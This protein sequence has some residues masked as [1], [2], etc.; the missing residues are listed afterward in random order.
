MAAPRSHVSKDDFDKHQPEPEPE[1]E[2]ERWQCRA[3]PVAL[4]L[5]PEAEDRDTVVELGGRGQE[6]E[7]WEAEGWDHESA[8]DGV[9]GSIQRQSLWARP[10]TFAQLTAWTTADLVPPGP[11][12]PSIR[13]AVH[14]K[15]IGGAPFPAMLA[16][17]DPSIAK[18]TG[19][20]QG[21]PQSESRIRSVH[22]SG[23]Y[24]RY[25]CVSFELYTT[26]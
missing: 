22:E 20:V 19:F 15:D 9:C 10:V 5:H 1:P 23:R 17:L 26:G 21:S 13:A 12:M 8:R 25:W 16:F 14:V 4:G 18:P 24:C 6:A 3:D 11:A 2:L 7:V